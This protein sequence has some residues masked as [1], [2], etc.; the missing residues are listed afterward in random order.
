VLER[1]AGDADV[2]VDNATAEVLRAV[3]QEEDLA[4]DQD[5]GQQGPAPPGGRVSQQSAQ[6]VPGSH[7]RVGRDRR[8][9]AL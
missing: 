5:C 6:R 7:G 8:E 2:A 9:R 1:L 4:D 3:L